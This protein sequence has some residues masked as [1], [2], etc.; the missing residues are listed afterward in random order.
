[1]ILTRKSAML[2]GSMRSDGYENSLSGLGVGGRTNANKFVASD[3]L[4]AE[5]LL[6]LYDNNWLARRIVETLPAQAL[7]KPILAEPKSIE[8][9]TKLNTDARFPNGIF[10][11]ALNMGRLCGGAMIVLGVKGSGAPLEAPLPVDKD[12]APRAGKVEFLDLLTRFQVESAAKYDT[13]DDPTTH[14]RTSVFK[15]K[16]GRLK[17]LKIHA[18]RM[19]FFE[20]DVKTTLS[21]SEQSDRDFPWQSCLQ[22]V[23]EALSNYGISWTAV[24]HLLQEASIAYLKL[25]G[26][27]DLLGTENRSL[28][29]ERMNLFSVGRTVA[30]TVFLDG[31][32]G[33]GDTGEE[34]GRVGVSFQDV[35]QLLEQ[36]TL[37]ISGA[38]AIPVSILLG[39][40][41][42]GLNATGEMDLRQFYDRVEEYRT[43]SVKPKLDTLLTVTGSKVAY[44]F[45]SLWDP[46]ASQLADIR[47]KNTGADFQLFTMGVFE[48][49]DVLRSR[50]KDGTLGIKFEDIEKLLAEKA[51]AKDGPKIEITPTENAR[52]I[53][54]NEIRANQGKE[55]LK[56]PTGGLDPDADLPSELYYAKKLAEIEA[57]AHVQSST[58]PAANGAAGPT[59]G[60]PSAPSGGSAGPGQLAQASGG[61]TQTRS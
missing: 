30:K 2:L 43:N 17:D 54:I 61:G 12:G 45:P 1:M 41:P 25:K 23:A 4:T 13:P 18:S 35:P 16:S 52:A 34:F 11:Q 32:N 3:T 59:S 39:Q 36:L 57:I 33:N 14:G 28:I 53:T 60:Q 50:S 47:V 7:R 10:K 6:T 24:S 42:S 56:L 48:P 27:T 8:S 5:Q 22:N 51:K 46:T 58:T 21:D 49:D 29:E 37:T 9:F 44:T 55:P 40:P 20:G 19:I 38:S 31:G 15:V 26:L